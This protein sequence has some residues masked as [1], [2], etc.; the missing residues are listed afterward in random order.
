MISI[1]FLFSIN[2]IHVQ[3]KHYRYHTI[4]LILPELAFY[5]YK[6]TSMKLYFF[7]KSNG[8]LHLKKNNFDMN[9]LFKLTINKKTTEFQYS[10]SV[11]GFLRNFLQ[12]SGKF[13]FQQSS[14]FSHLKTAGLSPEPQSLP[15]WILPA[16]NTLF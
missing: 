13:P 2:F 11:E 9:L 6:L 12:K 10:V 1:D 5:N 3:C 15:A 16:L 8:Y 14:S 4:I 7:L